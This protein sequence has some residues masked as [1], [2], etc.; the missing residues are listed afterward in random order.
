MLFYLVAY[1][2]V[3]IPSIVLEIPELG[4]LAIVLAIL[5]AIPTI[6]LSIRRLHDVDKSAWFL[7]V[8]VIPFG[9]LYLLYLYAKAG[10]PGDNRYGSAATAA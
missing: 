7:L 2:I 4:Y 1:L 9:S 8:S 5:L 3:L 6:S 10:T